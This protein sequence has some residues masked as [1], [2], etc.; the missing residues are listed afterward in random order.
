VPDV[1]VNTAQTYEACSSTSAANVD[2]VAP[3]SLELRTGE[4]VSIGAGF[5][6]GASALLGVTI[7]PALAGKAYLEDDSPGA[8]RLLRARFYLRLDQLTL[9]SGTVF[10]HFQARDA[11]GTPQLRVVLRGGSGTKL[12]EIAAREDPGSESSTSPI[13]VPSN[14]W[15]E[16]ELEWKAADPGRSDGQVRLW[17]DGLEKPGLA[18]LDNETGSIDVLRWGVI[19]G[20][21]TGSGGTVDLDDL[22]WRRVGLPIGS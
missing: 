11:G 10:D 3:G 22:S 14:G 7:D 1:A 4:R 15:I 17:I 16:V 5:S 19:E 2:V 6:V 9:G 13:V 8:E 12:L 21:D 18:G 20:L